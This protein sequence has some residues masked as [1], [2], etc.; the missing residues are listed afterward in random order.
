MTLTNIAEQA[1]S[2]DQGLYTF[3]LSIRR[4]DPK[5]TP[6]SL[7]TFLRSFTLVPLQKI[8]NPLLF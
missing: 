4:G 2:A 5:Q 8:K 6:Y 3:I 1:V 7:V